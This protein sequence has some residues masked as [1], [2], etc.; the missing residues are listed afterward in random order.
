MTGRVSTSRVPRECIEQAVCL[1]LHEL[2][3]G[4]QHV[5]PNGVSFGGRNAALPLGTTVAGHII[6]KVMQVLEAR[7][8]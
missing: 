2:F 5:A 7:D 6:D 8:A 1:A 4:P 3:D